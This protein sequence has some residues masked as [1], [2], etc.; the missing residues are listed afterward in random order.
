[1]NRTL[2]LSLFI[3]LTTVLACKKDRSTD[4]NTTTATTPATNFMINGI[5]DLNLAKGGATP[6]GLEVKY[7]SGKQETV[8]L[9]TDKLPN[10]V[11]T[12]IDPKSGTPT[13]TSVITFHA[14]S[15]ADGGTF[16]VKVI[17]TNASG[18]VLSYDLNLNIP[19]NCAKVIAGNYSESYN[20]QGYV[21]SSAH[22]AS[23]EADPN[24]NGKIILHGFCST[25]AT[26]LNATF[27]CSANIIQISDQKPTTTIEVSGTGVY[28]NRTIT[29]TF[30]LNGHSCTSTATAK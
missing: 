4:S 5:K 23:I 24:E 17:G 10:G 18:Q 12:D 21:Y 7:T 20:C 22:D 9:T 27:D 2:K 26:T 25:N 1:M 16:P 8:T 15:S 19:S 6:L 14:S 28:N 29:T 30:L 11:T 3:L 13:Y